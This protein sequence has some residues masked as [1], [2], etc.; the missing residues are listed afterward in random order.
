LDYL[1]FVGGDELKTLIICASIHHGNTLKIAKVIAEVIGAEIVRT[2]E[3][4]PDQVAAYD[5]VGFGSGVYYGALHKSLCKFVEK[6]PQVHGNKVF[7]FSTS[8]I[9]KIPLI[10]DYHR[11]IKKALKK[12]GYE[13]IG[14][15]TCRGYNTHGPFKWFGGINK[16]RPNERDL[17]H[18]RS[19][20]E[21]ILER[22]EELRR[23]RF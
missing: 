4:E 19:F 15:F 23:S 9:S 3:V 8:G 11:S 13:V 12:R 17:E 20:A 6:L 7:I 1:I 10:H 16:G 21:E 14:E 18:A 22:L 2:W 5:L